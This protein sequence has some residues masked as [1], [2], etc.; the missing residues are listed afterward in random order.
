[1][2]VQPARDFDDLA[3]SPYDLAAPIDRAVDEAEHGKVIYLHRRKRPT[4]AVMPAE[5]AEAALA[6]LENVEDTAEVAAPRA[7]RSAG[8]RGVSWEQLKAEMDAELAQ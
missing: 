8:E 3:S 1:M 4:V 6:A 2:A 7:R 5:V